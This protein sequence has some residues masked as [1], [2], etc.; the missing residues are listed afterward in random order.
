MTIK[1]FVGGLFIVAAALAAAPARA[2]TGHANAYR[3]AGGSRPYTS[4]TAINATTATEIA[5]YSL[6]RPSLT[7]FNNSSVHIFLSSS[8]ASVA[9]HQQAGFIILSSATFKLG[10]H[11][12]AVSAL[13]NS[14]AGD[15]RCWEGRTE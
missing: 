15:V 11:L 13:T 7:C 5:A 2:D 9:H 1:Q 8:G 12:G 10:A 14:G 4:G 6:V 3:V